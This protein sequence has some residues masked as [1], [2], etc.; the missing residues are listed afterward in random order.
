MNNLDGKI[1]IV[2]GSTSGIG[3]VTAKELAKMGAT[4]VLVVR[5]EARGKEALAEV[6]TNHVIFMQ[7]IGKLMYDQIVIF[8]I[9]HLS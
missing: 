6:I 7:P 4:I 8:T 1:C 5:D 3:L 9:S 2:T